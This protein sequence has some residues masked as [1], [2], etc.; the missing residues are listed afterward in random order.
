MYKASELTIKA[1]VGDMKF[2]ELHHMLPRQVQNG[3]EKGKSLVIKT[4]K[5]SGP[6]IDRIFASVSCDD[7]DFD[8]DEEEMTF[9]YHRFIRF[10][11]KKKP[12][13]RLMEEIFPIPKP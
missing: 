5:E 2:F 11:R 3:I 7:D 12:S 6:N 13:S 10:L 8:L 9:L 1:L 4:T